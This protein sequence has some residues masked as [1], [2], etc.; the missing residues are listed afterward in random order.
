MVRSTLASANTLD[1]Q[2]KLAQDAYFGTLGAGHVLRLLTAIH[3]CKCC[4][5]NWPYI[6]SYATR[7]FRMLADVPAFVDIRF[8]LLLH[9]LRSPELTAPRRVRHRAMFCWVNRN[10]KQREKYLPTLLDAVGVTH[11]NASSSM[12]LLVN[13]RSV[14]RALRERQLR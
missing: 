14:R 3:S 7:H 2:K 10:R 11:A 1:A 8:E 4:T 13:C 9:L 6:S 12:P 5:R